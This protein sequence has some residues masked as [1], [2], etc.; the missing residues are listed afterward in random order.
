[1]TRHQQITP[2]LDST[3]TTDQRGA[4]LQRRVN[5]QLVPNAP[6]GD[7]TDIG[8]FGCSRRSSSLRQ[9]QAYADPGTQ[10]TITVRMTAVLTEPRPLT[11]PRA[12]ARAVVGRT[13]RTL[14][15]RSRSPGRD[16]QSFTVP[17][18]NDALDEAGET[19]NLTSATRPARCSARRTRP[20]TIAD[21]DPLPALAVDSPT[22]VAEGNAPSLV[23]CHRHPLGAQRQGRHGQVP[24]GRRT[25]KAPA[26]Y[27]AK[28]AATLTLLRG[29]PA[30]P[31]P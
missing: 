23:N 15:A 24:D 1:M 26:D 12:T 19:V 29:R 8:A 3:L 28:G 6:G 20:L 5:L 27:T 11:T 16:T 14:S 13:T 21:D 9:L 7:G 22:G 18:N 31:S 4:E 10:G 17:I 30:R 25:A 2:V